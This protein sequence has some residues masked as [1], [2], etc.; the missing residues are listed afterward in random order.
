MLLDASVALS[1]F[2][3]RVGQDV[4]GPGIVLIP[5]RATTCP[6]SRSRR[7]KLAGGATLIGWLRAR[8]IS[9]EAA[10]RSW[11]KGD[12]RSSAC[13][14]DS[15]RGAIPGRRAAGYGIAQSVWECNMFEALS[16]YSATIQ[17]QPQ[18]EYTAGSQR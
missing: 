3:L 6:S 10:L 18:K 13:Y 1:V 16:H 12:P 15:T 2:G 5:S 9:N 11:L 4:D 7:R 17:S 8:A 14:T